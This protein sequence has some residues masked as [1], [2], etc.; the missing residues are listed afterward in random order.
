MATRKRKQIEVN[1]DTEFQ[2]KIDQ[3]RV[4]KRCYS[5]VL[6]IYIFLNLNFKLRDFFYSLV[7]II[8]KMSYNAGKGKVWND[9]S[10]PSSP[11]FYQRLWLADHCV[12]GSGSLCCVNCRNQAALRAKNF[13]ACIARP[14]FN[15]RPQG[16]FDCS[17]NTS[18]PPWLVLKP[19]Q[20]DANYQNQTKTDSPFH[21]QTW[22]SQSKTFLNPDLPDKTYPG[23]QE[24]SCVPTLPLTLVREWENL[25]VPGWTKAKGAN[26]EMKAP[27]EYVVTVWCCYWKES[28][29]DEQSWQWH[30][31]HWFPTHNYF[32]L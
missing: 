17:K 3:Q 21:C 1:V 31:V 6:H 18:K 5:T 28:I 19:K 9:K 25:W 32:S 2:Q 22:I 29:L 14:L 12:A 16:V 23:T 11:P 26:I 7:L 20:Q 27:N 10:S 8:Q 13:P 4:R 30:W 15:A 24:V